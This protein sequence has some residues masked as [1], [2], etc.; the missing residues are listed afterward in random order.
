MARKPAIHD[1]P[2]REL[3]LPVGPAGV[4]FNDVSFAYPSR[5]DQLL[6]NKFSLELPAGSF[7]AITGPSGAGKST[8]MTLLERF[9]DPQHGSVAIGGE[10][11]RNFRL[12]HLRG[13]IIAYVPQEPTLF[14]GSILENVAYGI[15]AAD[16]GKLELEKQ[17]A[18]IVSAC[19]VANAHGFISA[20]PE[21]Y[22]T[23]VG[24]N[25][26]RL[27]G[28]ER[29]RVALARAIVGNPSILLLDEVSRNLDSLSE[30]AV[31]RGLQEASK[32]RTTVG[33]HGGRTRHY[34]CL[35]KLTC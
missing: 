31:H 33:D 16:G 19:A 10:N 32:G 30:Q 34:N 15:F 8:L 6:L 18:A 12:A 1:S 13:K 14:D 7:T 20:L 3:D 23:Q 35:G 27:S 25:G 4:S 5:P 2:G 9:Y 29:A 28:G 22:D 11:V 24:Q 21:G 17:R 26:L